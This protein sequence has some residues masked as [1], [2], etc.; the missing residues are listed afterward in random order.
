MINVRDYGAAGDGTTDDRQAIQDALDVGGHVYVPPGV[1]AV[2]SGVLRIQRRTRLTADPAATILRAGPTEG[3]LTNAEPGGPGGYS[4][5]GSILIEGGTWDVNGACEPGYA[6]GITVAHAED[7][8]VRDL[9]ILNVPGWHA[10]E[11]NSSRSVLVD[12]C[13]FKGFRHDGDRNF[14]E[15]IQVDAAI[16]ESTGVAPFDGTVCD[17]VEVRSCRFG[18]GGADGTEPWPRGI[19]THTAPTTWHRNIKIVGNTFDAASWCAIRT[20]WWDRCLI[21]GNQIIGATGDGIVVD[22]NSRYTLVHGN[23]VVDSGRNGILVAHGCTQVDVRDNTVIGSGQ[24]A[25][26]TYGGVRVAGSSY[27]RVTGNTIRRRAAGNDARYGLWIE[28]SAAGIQR[29]GND[30][31]Y[32]GYSATLGDFSSGAVT[33]AT[34]AI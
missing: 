28:A 15:A 34:D 1:Y 4:G 32:G 6:C 31:R 22:Y 20:Y 23:Q 19:G 11:I 21:T 7:V 17:G 5:H 33:A 9:T 25:N 18:G 30:C 3:L 12:N 10:V 2:T 8:T 14:S 29:Y 16:G 13:R 27:V 26:N 24:A